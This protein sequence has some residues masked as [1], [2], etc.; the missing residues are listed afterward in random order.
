[1]SEYKELTALIQMYN[2]DGWQHYMRPKLQKDRDSLIQ[3]MVYGGAAD[4][5]GVAESI[6]YLDAWLAAE[7]KTRE[8]LRKLQAR[9]KDPDAVD[10]PPASQIREPI[11]FSDQP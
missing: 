8:M 2:T 7:E 6:K 11:D 5:K 10:D 3:L 9:E 1:M 4:N